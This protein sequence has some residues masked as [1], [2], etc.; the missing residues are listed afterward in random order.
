MPKRT[1]LYDTHDAA[2]A[3][4]VDFGGWDMPLHYGSQ[5]EEH[6][7]VR[8]G[9][10]LFDVSHMTI[11]DMHGQRVG[12]FLRYL[13]AND[14]TKLKTAGKALYTC[15]LNSSGGVIDDLIIYFLGA[16]WYRA[17][18]NAATRDKDLAWIQGQAAPFGVEVTERRNTAMIAVQGPE[19]RERVHQALGETVR[20]ATALMTPFSMVRV[21]E[22][23]IDRTG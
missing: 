12:E 20:A 18:V 5:L 4:M 21:S 9:A 11:L 6:H 19:A 15:M 22:V 2:G 23:F 1:P 17:V 7:V 14:V 16:T 10:G 8:R 13:V 3:K